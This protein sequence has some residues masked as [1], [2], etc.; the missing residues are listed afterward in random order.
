VK[1]ILFDKMT[2]NK[3]LKT[4]AQAALEFL[5]T[6]GWAILSVLVVISALAYFGIFNT[7]KYVND[8]CDFGDQLNCED[9]ILHRNSTVAFQLRNN[10]PVTIDINTVVIKTDFGSSNCPMS[11]VSPNSSIMPGSLFEVKC[12]FSATNLALSDKFR[13]KAIIEFK[14]TGISNP[15]HNQ[16]GD[17][18]IAVSP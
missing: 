14:K 1:N 9:Y 2:N 3:K 8:K 17:M 18:L 13:L 16:T 5:V 6:Y 10:F 11:G 12:K 15:F 7:S 4:R